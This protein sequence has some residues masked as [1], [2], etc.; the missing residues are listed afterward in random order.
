M[1]NE[2]DRRTFLQIAAGGAIGLTLPSFS[3]GT[4]TSKTVSPFPLESV[5]L[6]PS[7]FLNA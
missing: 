2:L 4:D 1:I 3:F 5:R 7:P 6:K